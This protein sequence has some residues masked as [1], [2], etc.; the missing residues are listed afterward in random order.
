[1]KK[2][3]FALAVAATFIAGTIFTNCQSPADKVDD[4]KA[5]VKDAK[6][7]LNEAQKDANAEAQKTAAAEEWRMFKADAEM[8]IKRNEDDIADLRAKMK[9]SG[10][11]LSA[12]YAKSI[13]EI[14]LKNKDIKSKLDGYD[15]NQSNWESFKREFNHDMD[16]L[17]KAMK[18]LT[19]D[20]KK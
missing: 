7:D 5:N 6:Q 14:E 8:K 13:D 10:K 1:M 20:N 2:S 3:I 15:K 12:A 4:A 11:K 18:D 16:E 19:V 17:G 9:S